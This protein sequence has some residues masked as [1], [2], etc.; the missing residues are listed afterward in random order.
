MK[1]LIRRFWKNKQLFAYFFRILI[2]LCYN[3]EVIKGCEIYETKIYANDDAI[4][5][6]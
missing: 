3:K 4:F 2:Y 6:N 1:V 5:R